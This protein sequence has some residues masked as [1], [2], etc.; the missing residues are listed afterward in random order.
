MKGITHFLV[1]VATA[2]C[3]PLAVRSAYDDKSYLILLGGLFG[4]MSDT[5]DFKFARYFWKHDYRVRITEDNLDPAAAA[6]TIAKAIDEAA[7]TGRPVRVKLDILR[8][9]T[10]YYRTY[11]VMIDDRKK[12]VSCVIGPLKTMSHCMGRGE[13]MPGEESKKRAVEKDGPI[14]VLEKFA[15]EAPALPNSMPVPTRGHVASFKA[16]VNNTYYSDAEVGIFSGPDFEFIPQ[17]DGRVRIDFIPWHR[18]WTHSITLGLLMG[19][20]GF[21]LFADWG[22]LFAGNLAAFAN[23]FA[24]NAFFISI[25]AFWAHVFV[26]QTGH[27]GSNL[28]PPWTKFR[29]LGWRWCTSASPFPNLM[30]NYISAAIIL[31]NMNAFA[32]APVFTPPWAAGIPGGFTNMTYCILSLLNYVGVVIVLPLLFF[33]AIVRLY[34]HIY[35][36]SRSIRLEEAF[37]GEDW[38]GGGGDM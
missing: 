17:K 25:L 18:R 7:A 23:P 36:K 10:N 35:Y 1:G 38:A 4:I 28:F 37:S 15:K 24:V 12:Q 21:A 8:F 29:S 13:N 22:A 5:L 20:I 26:D 9:S 19:P 33:Y 14:A 3:F 34:R 31:W 16:D 30:V 11:A 32:P 2:S 27:L 6:E